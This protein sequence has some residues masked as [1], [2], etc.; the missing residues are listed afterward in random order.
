[1]SSE[2]QQHTE[3]RRGFRIRGQLGEEENL[4]SLVGRLNGQMKQAKTMGIN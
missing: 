3:A 1:M 4:E 2:E